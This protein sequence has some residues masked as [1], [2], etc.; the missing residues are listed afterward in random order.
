METINK[1][2]SGPKTRKHRRDSNSGNLEHYTEAPHVR[3][4]LDK[5]LH[6]VL[7]VIVK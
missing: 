6:I 2:K 7:L 5:S 1:H 3:N 4:T